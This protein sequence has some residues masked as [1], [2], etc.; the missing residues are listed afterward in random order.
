MEQDE[1]SISP[2]CSLHEQADQ[3]FEAIHKEMCGAAGDH[4][5][6]RA[7]SIELNFG[8]SEGNIR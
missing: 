4:I 2:Y 5:C 1:I 8:T 3:W 7:S 6:F